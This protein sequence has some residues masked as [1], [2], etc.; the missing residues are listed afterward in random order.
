MAKKAKCPPCEEGAPLWMQTYGDMVTLLLCLFILLFTTGKATPQEIQLI[1]SAFNN[2]MGFFTGGQ[3]LSRGR[4]EEMGLTVESLPSQT[5]GRSLA[6]AKMQAKSIFKPEI[7]ARKIRVTEDER[8]LVISLVGADYF[9]PGSALLTPAIE[10]VL[11]KSSGL[12]REIDRFIRVEGFAA[13]GEDAALAASADM[14][15]SERG[16]VNSWDLAGARSINTVIFLQD[17]GVRPDLMQAVSF[18]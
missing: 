12:L 2:S 9:Q 16:Y 5:T 8:G 18:G 7:K 6:R 4:L 17:Q 1:L 13:S 15:R 3:T 11:R 14:E 10:E